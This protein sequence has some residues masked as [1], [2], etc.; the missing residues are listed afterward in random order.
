MYLFVYGT[1][2]R[3][4]S[5]HALLR[6]A[7]YIGEARIRGYSLYRLGGFPGIVVNYENCDAPVYGEVYEVDDFQDLD[8]LEGYDEDTQS[9]MYV[10]MLKTVTFTRWSADNIEDTPP[11]WLEV[12]VYIWN[13]S[14]EGRELIE[15]GTWR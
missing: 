9:G 10:R 1:L 7:T 13:R 15:S 11:D 12:H 4:H 6:G 3:G 14:V 2:K 8:A 5:N